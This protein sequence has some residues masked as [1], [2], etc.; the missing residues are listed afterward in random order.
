MSRTMLLFIMFL[1]GHL[2]R[3]IRRSYERSRYQEDSCVSFWDNPAQYYSELWK[4]SRRKVYPLPFR[5]GPW[6]EAAAMAT[7][8]S[9]RAY[10]L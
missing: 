1:L 7:M 9:W 10:N 6:L 4:L 2:K 3:E 5:G 8:D